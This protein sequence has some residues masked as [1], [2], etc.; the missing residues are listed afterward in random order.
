MKKILF[1]STRNPYSNRYSGD[2]I[3]SKKIL[4]ILKK[5]N[6]LDLVTL[7]EK[8]DF[9]QKRTFI[10]E[11]PNFILKFFYIIRSLFYFQP[12]Q[13]GLFYSNKMQKFINDNAYNYDIIFFIILDQVNIYLKIFTEK[14]LLKWEICTQVIIYKL[15]IL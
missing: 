7:D 11:K 14:K 15:L 13:F 5:N 2:V 1:I 4:S 10:F 8:E 12:I 6:S 3:G 9:S